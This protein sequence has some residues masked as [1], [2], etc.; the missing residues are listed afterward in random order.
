MFT[1]LATAGLLLALTLCAPIAEAAKIYQLAD[2]TVYLKDGTTDQY[3]GTTKL[4]MPHKTTPCKEWKTHIQKIRKRRVRFRV[5]L[6]TLWSCGCRHGPTA[7]IHSYSYPSMD[8]AH[9]S[10]KRRNPP[11]TS[12]PEADTVS[13]PTAVYGSTMTVNFWWTTTARYP[14]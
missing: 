13:V 11:L 4:S 3:S 7:A 6:S 9:S 14:P 1:K 8:G 12:I 10:T 5:P 2:A